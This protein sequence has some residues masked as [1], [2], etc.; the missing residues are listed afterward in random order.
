MWDAQVARSS[1][2]RVEGAEHLRAG[3]VH[4]LD[5]ALAAAAARRS[6]SLQRRRKVEA[7]RADRTHG[8]GCCRAGRPLGSHRH[9]VIAVSL[10]VVGRLVGRAERAPSGR[11]RR[12]MHGRWGS[13]RGGAPRS[14]AH[15]YGRGQAVREAEGLRPAQ[16]EQ[17]WL[18]LRTPHANGSSGFSTG[19][20]SPKAELHEGHACASNRM[21]RGALAAYQRRWHASFAPREGGRRDRRVHRSAASSTPL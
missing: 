9:D 12:R 7:V 8:C 11:R 20:A 5:R 1:S 17:V 16:L 19:G 21:A 3:G 10:E 13:D 2:L 6:A 4:A 15:S 18:V 14:H